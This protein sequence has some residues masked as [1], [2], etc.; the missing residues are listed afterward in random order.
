MGGGRRAF[1]SQNETDPE[2]NK[3]DTS[4]GRLDGR[5]L[6]NVRQTPHTFHNL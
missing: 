2:T 3:V 4:N 6:V 1:L 5:N